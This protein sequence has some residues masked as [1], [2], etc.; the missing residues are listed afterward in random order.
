MWCK[1]F[2]DTS[3]VVEEEG[4]IV[5]FISGFI[6]PQTP[7]ILFIWQV[8]VHESQRGKGLATRMLQNILNRTVCED[9]QYLEAT[10]SPSNTG[11]IHLF[12]GLAKKQDTTCNVRQCFTTDDF[13]GEGHEDEELYRIGPL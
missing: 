1:F 4:D 13:P 2:S 5:G 10:V 3:I 9:V 6:K 7:H 12:K 8:A 11:S